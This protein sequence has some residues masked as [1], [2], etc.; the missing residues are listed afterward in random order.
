[1]SFKLDTHIHT[2]TPDRGVNSYFCK[3]VWPQV[4]G[5]V[6]T[7]PF[8][9][10]IPFQEFIALFWGASEVISS[11]KMKLNISLPPTGCQKLTEVNNE[12]KLCKF[13]EKRVTREG[14]A[15]ALG[16]KWKDFVVGIV[17]GNDQQDLLMKQEILT[18][19]HTHLL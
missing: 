15:A 7:N 19:G 14:A 12:G 16:D 10:V 2:H 6:K 1:M 4:S 3:S 5:V 8:Y 11:F 17:E 13:Y 9:S 18:H